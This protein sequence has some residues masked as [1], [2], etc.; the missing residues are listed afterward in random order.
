MLV[1]QWVKP[2]PLEVLIK[3]R[4]KSVLYTC[5]SKES[6]TGHIDVIVV[7]F[8]TVLCEF[9]MSQLWSIWQF[10][11]YIHPHI[12]DIAGFDIIVQR[13]P[14]R[15][16]QVIKWKMRY[17]P[18]RSTCY[19]GNPDGFLKRK[20]LQLLINSTS[21]HVHSTLFLLPCSLRD[22]VLQRYYYYRFYFMQTYICRSLR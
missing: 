17:P 3:Q 7:L 18:N 15:W 9:C 11:P 13:M 21:P 10:L 19:K 1:N 20:A 4:K 22:S 16:R 12:H 5:L 8:S 2:V 14:A 6:L